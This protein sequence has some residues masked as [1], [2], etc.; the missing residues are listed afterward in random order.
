[1]SIDLRAASVDYLQARRARGYRLA[2]H[3]WLITSFL[4]GLAARG[5]TAIGITDALAFAQAKPGTQHRWHAAR[6]QAIRAFAAYVHDLDPAAAELIPDGLITAKATR[7]ISYLYSHKQVTELMSRAAGLS[8]PLLAAS[9]HTLIGLIATTGLRSGEAIA[10]DIDNLSLD[11]R[12]MTVTGKYGKQRLVPL[13]PSTVEALTGYQRVRVTLTGTPPTGP[14]LIGARWGR[15]NVNTARAAFRAV[16]LACDLASR[17]GCAPPRLHDL[18]HT[19]A[20]NT[21][22]D[23]YRHGG[24]VD[25][26]IAALANYLGHV[27]PVNTYWHLSASPEL[28]ALACDRITAHQHRRRS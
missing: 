20:V 15:L 26:R 16:T 22:I 13:H 1:M 11:E 28:M 27:D 5:A 17:P 25:A 23:A 3:G 12:V 4:E 24:D 2:D 8:P 6:L 9:V 14:L 7:R 18:R 10:L 21:L 19:F